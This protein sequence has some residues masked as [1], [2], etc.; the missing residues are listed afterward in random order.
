MKRLLT[1]SFLALF[2]FAISG[3]KV[4][5]PNLSSPLPGTETSGMTPELFAPTLSPLVTMNAT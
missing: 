5:T 2:S 1:L 4:N 3:Q